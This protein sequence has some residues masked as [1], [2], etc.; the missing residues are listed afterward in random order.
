MHGRIHYS[1]QIKR[2]CSQSHQP[3]R[4]HYH[5]QF[6][7][8]GVNCRCCPPSLIP[9]IYIISISSFSLPFFSVPFL[10]ISSPVCFITSTFFL[11]FFLRLPSPSLDNIRV[12]V[13]VWRLRGKI[14]RTAM[15]WIVRN[16]VHSQQHIYMSSSYR[17]NRLGLSHY[18]PYA[19]RRGNCLCCIIVA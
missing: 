3:V 8:R 13:I 9:C 11:P 4:V 15:C 18:D 17:S 5:S 7:T 2:H 14:I 10:S 6:V 16:N 12:M 19:A 1:D